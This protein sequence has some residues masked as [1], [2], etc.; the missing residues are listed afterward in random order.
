MADVKSRAQDADK[1]LEQYRSDA[2]KKLEE[3]RKS[4]GANLSSAV[5]K[6][7]KKVEDGTAKTQSYIGSWFGGS[8]K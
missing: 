4:T 2:E 5:D 3:A 6:F 7:D 1:K 8:K